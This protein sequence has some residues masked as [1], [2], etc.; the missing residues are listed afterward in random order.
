MSF[1]KKIIQKAMQKATAAHLFVKSFSYNPKT[2]S[3]SIHF[4]SNNEEF[5]K[6]R[7]LKDVTKGQSIEE[8][9]LWFYLNGKLNERELA[10]TTLKI[11]L[12]VLYYDFVDKVY[13]YYTFDNLQEKYEC[14]MDTDF[15]AAL[16]A[17]AE[18][19][20]QYNIDFFIKTNYDEQRI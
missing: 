10:R 17:Q 11:A 5:R 6:V 2:K 12:R 4:F 15:C 16:V 1:K 9:N 19:D 18:R 13:F 20:K 14:S 8:F 7:P 3:V